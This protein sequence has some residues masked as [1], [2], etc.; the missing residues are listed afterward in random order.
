MTDLNNNTIVEKDLKYYLPTFKRFPIAIIKGKGTRVWDADGNM[1]LDALAGIAVNNLGHCHPAVVRA[2]QKQ[3]E[4]LIH[5]SNFFSTEP[6]STLAEELC[7]AS[8]MHSAF[9]TNS[10]AE[11]VEGAVKVARKYAHS[12][13]RGGEI[14][15]FTKA[16][17]GRTLATI[18]MGKEKMQQGFAPIPGGFKVVQWEDL[19]AIQS[20]ASKETAAIIIEPVQ[21]EGGVFPVDKTFLEALRTFCDE[22]DIVLIFDEVQCGMGRTGELFAKDLYGVQPDIMALAKGLGGGAPIGAILA[23]EATSATINFGDHGTTFGGN[24]LVCAA[25]LATLEELKKPTLMEEVRTKGEYLKNSVESRNHPHITD[26]RVKGLMVGI[27]FDIPT[28]PLV[29]KMLELGVIANATADTVLRL[30]PPLTITQQELETVIDTMFNA[31]DQLETN[32]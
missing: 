7:N 21:G 12:K 10:G 16:F 30:V 2:I 28:K 4:Q 15:A 1:Y 17:H 22:Q 32:E 23:N 8:G 29:Q 27:E 20:A 18:A 11:S 6:Q 9:F 19:D 13:G 26:V 3:A 24:P 14:I 25:A 31:L 5:I